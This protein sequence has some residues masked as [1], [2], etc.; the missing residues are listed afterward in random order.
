MVLFWVFAKK[1]FF[2][3][4]SGGEEQ[5]IDTFAAARLR[6]VRVPFV[7][8]TTSIIKTAEALAFSFSS[9]LSPS[10]ECSPAA[11]ESGI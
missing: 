9:Y 5:V 8:Q 3:P 7:I 10:P 2:S 4:G 11:S 6:E 1:C